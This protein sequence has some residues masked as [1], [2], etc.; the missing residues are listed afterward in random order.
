M[1]IAG[2]Y[3]TFINY[4]KTLKQKARYYCLALLQCIY[5]SLQE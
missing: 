1:R 3:N 4:I 5:A 2:Q